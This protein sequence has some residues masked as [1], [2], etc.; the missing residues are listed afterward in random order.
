V[1]AKRAKK[2]IHSEGLK[3]FST[4]LQSTHFGVQRLQHSNVSSDLPFVLENGEG[5]VHELSEQQ[6]HVFGGEAS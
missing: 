4:P 5:E 6:S 3:L 1:V 2:D